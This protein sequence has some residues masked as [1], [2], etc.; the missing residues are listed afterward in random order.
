MTNNVLNQ[1]FYALE[2]TYGMLMVGCLV[3][4]LGFCVISWRI[5]SDK[6]KMNDLKMLFKS[7][8][9]LSPD[10]LIQFNAEIASELV[11]L[12]ELTG[13]CWKNN[14]NINCH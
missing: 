12:I 1:T 9:E 7:H 4:I 13:H 8:L 10:I 14:E 11:R 5:R 2:I 6:D 3:M